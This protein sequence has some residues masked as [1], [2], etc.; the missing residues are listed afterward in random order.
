MVEIHDDHF[1]RDEEDHVWLKAVVTRGWVAALRRIFKL[2]HSVPGLFVALVLA[3][4]WRPNCVDSSL[5]F[6][7]RGI[8]K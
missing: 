2:L 3:S 7:V 1:A 5:L 6:S 8:C 4:I